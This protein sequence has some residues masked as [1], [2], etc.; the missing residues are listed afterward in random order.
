VK[1][2]H[3]C[4]PNDLI[5][6]TKFNDSLILITIVLWNYLNVSL[7]NEYVAEVTIPTQ[8][9]SITNAAPGGSAYQIAVFTSN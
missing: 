3:T 2:V 9:S 5:F 4:I 1:T 8:L 7:V 6:T